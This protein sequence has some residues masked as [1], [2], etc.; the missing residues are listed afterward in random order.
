ML[1]ATGVSTDVEPTGAGGGAGRGGRE[2]SVVHPIDN[3]RADMTGPSF[4]LGIFYR[5]LFL[6]SFE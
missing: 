4:R 6:R 1:E 5:S 2:L 3:N